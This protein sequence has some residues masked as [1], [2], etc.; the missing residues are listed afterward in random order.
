MKE[1]DKMQRHTFYSI[2]LNLK[3][4]ANESLLKIKNNKN[5]KKIS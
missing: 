1:D 3:Q 4:S 5:N 2:H